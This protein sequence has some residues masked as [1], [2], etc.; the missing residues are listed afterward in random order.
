MLGFKKNKAGAINSI[1]GK[2]TTFN[3]NIIADG[4]LRVDGQAEG[5]L[6]SNSDVIIGH[7]AK[8]NINVKA[9][10]VIIS[11]SL[12][13]MVIAEKRVEIESTGIMIGDIRTAEIAIDDGAVFAGSCEM[14]YNKDEILIDTSFPEGVFKPEGAF[15][16]D[17][18]SKPSRKQ[19]E[20]KE[21]VSKPVSKPGS[22]KEDDASLPEKKHGFVAYSDDDKEQ[23][24]KKSGSI[25]KKFRNV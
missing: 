12:K 16:K 17:D 1:I 15:K 14:D 9:V 18:V 5:E 20:E 4:L 24:E 8:A 2:G 21:T 22:K 11:G 25:Y 7:G 23:G 6:I 13:G 10:N 3:G 19:D